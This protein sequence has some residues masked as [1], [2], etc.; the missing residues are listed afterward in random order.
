MRSGD[1]IE[2]GLAAC[3]VLIVRRVPAVNKKIGV[4]M[5]PHGLIGGVIHT[6]GLTP[7]CVEVRSQVADPDTLRFQA[8][9]PAAEGRRR[10]FS[11]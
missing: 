1:R 5:T 2:C 8:P 11:E 4:K 9:P 7:N 3:S 6:T 10:G